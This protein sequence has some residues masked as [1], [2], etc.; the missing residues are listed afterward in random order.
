MKKYEGTRV[1][2]LSRRRLMLGTSLVATL[3]AVSVSVSSADVNKKP[4]ISFKEAQSLTDKLLAE[5]IAT[6]QKDFDVTYSAA[7]VSDIKKRIWDKTQFTMLQF[8]TPTEKD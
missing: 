7:E 2:N 4:E 6:S 1:M 5:A 3:A 8:Y